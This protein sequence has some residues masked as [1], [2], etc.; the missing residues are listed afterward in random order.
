MT[1]HTNNSAP[2]HSASNSNNFHN[3]KS[4]NSSPNKNAA[5]TASASH[6]ADQLPK[7]GFGVGLRSCHFEWLLKNDLNPAALNP[8]E[9]PV[10]WFE[11]IS[12]NFMDNHGFAHYMLDRVRERYPIVM[13]GVSL[14]I[15]S[16]DPLNWDYLTKLNALVQGIQPAWVSDHI[17]WTG[18]SGVN[19][20]DLLPLPYT[21]ESLRHVIQRVNE[22]QDFLQRPLVLENPSSYL[23]FQQSE[24]T[25]PEFINALCAETGCGLLLDVNNV[26]VSS[27]NHGFDA[28]EYIRTLPHKQIVQMHLAGPTHCGSHI[29]DTHDTEVPRQVWQLYQLAQELAPECSTLLEWDANIPEFPQLVSELNKARQALTGELPGK[30][31]HYQPSQQNSGPVVSTPVHHNLQAHNLNEHRNLDEYRYAEAE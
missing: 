6:L 13:H 1:T 3:S 19:T 27:F 15:G 10:D 26:F 17:C 22:V 29:I 28:E 7:L 16:S 11:I 20:H 30:E 21:E 12:E 31:L 18:I 5:D 4:N 8:V 25:E 24:L 9:R 2:N 23:Q 14:S